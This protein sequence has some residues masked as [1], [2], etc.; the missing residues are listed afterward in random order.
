MP[1]IIVDITDIGTRIDSLVSRYSD[2]SRSK[3]VEMIKSNK[4]FCN[5]KTIKPNYKVRIGDVVEFGTYEAK[6]NHLKAIPMDLDIVFE[7]DSLIVINKPRGLA[8]HGGKGIH[9]PTLVDGVFHHIKP[10]KPG[11]VH[12]IDKN[13]SGLIVIA[14]NDI[15]HNFLANQLLDKTMS[16]HYL[17]IVDGT[18]NHAITIDSPIGIDNEDNKKMTVDPINGK[19]AITYIKPLETFNNHS[20]VHCELQ[21]GRTHQIR[22]HLSSINH[23]IVEDPIYNPNSPDGLGQYLFAYRLQ[24]IHPVSKELVVFEVDKPH[25]FTE[26][27]QQLILE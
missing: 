13:T 18:I 7:D 6:T 4:V 22:V 23:A 1:T 12:R 15:S 20:L 16:R 10:L 8:V 26:K 14:K 19:T 27:I 3:I 2:H 24:F 21:T 9:E 5:G 11:L 25:Y 17:A